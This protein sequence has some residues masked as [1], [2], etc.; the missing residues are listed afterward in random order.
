MYA[1]RSYY[2]DE[3]AIHFVDMSDEAGAIC[4]YRIRPETD[5][6]GP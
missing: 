1:I 4:F 6:E 5:S 3:S 2:A